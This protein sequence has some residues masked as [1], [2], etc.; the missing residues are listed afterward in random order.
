VILPLIVFPALKYRPSLRQTLTS[1]SPSGFQWRDSN[2]QSDNY[3]SGV[4]PGH[5]QTLSDLLCRSVSDEV[6]K[7]FYDIGTRLRMTSTYHL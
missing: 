7:K 4:L 2:P 1:F 5:S 3:L 6:E